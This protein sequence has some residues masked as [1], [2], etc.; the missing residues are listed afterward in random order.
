MFLNR[1]RWTVFRR[2][3]VLL[4][5]LFAL[6]TL[7][8]RP[9]VE[10]IGFSPE[11]IVL[12][13]GGAILGLINV[14]LVDWLKHKFGLNQTPALLFAYVFSFLLAFVALL[15]GGG[16]RIA[17]LTW[18]N[19]FIVATMILAMAQFVYRVLNPQPQTP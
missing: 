10:G 15:I 5:A 1:K 11:Q 4:I 8:F 19:F 3:A 13:I 17:D 12:F 7:A 9:L 16:L 14:P 2:A 18:P 6:C